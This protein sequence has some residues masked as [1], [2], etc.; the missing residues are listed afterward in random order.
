M[1]ELFIL[2]RSRSPCACMADVLFALYRHILLDVVGVAV[3]VAV[4]TC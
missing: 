4:Q 2:V 3:W 1:D